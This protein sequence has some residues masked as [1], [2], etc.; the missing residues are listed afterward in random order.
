M[1][2]VSRAWAP[3]WPC[4]LTLLPANAQPLHGIAA[5]ATF[6]GEAIQQLEQASLV[7]ISSPQLDSP[8]SHARPQKLEPALSMPDLF[9]LST[10]DSP[11]PM[12]SPR[13]ESVSGSVPH[14]FSSV[15][16]WLRVC[17]LCVRRLLD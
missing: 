4:R 7:P 15:R 1:R 17:A 10:S 5:N 8:T 14:I 11:S 2:N 9:V 12:P 6:L 16:A 3:A 13:K